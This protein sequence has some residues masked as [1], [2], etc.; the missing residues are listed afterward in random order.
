M[1]TL[2]E[3]LARH[4]AERPDAPAVV[5]Q[6]GTWT[7]ADLDGRAAAIA[8]AVIE[9]GGP[10][11]RVGLVVGA[12]ALGIAAVHGV[13][14]SG[15]S[16][17]LVHPRLTPAEVAALLA[18]AGCRL[19]VIDPAT[20][21]SA[22]AGLEVLRLDAIDSQ[23]S[24]DT[25][26][27]PGSGE[28]VVPTSGTTARP[29][30]ARLPLD[31]SAASAAAWNV[32]LP[33][34]TGWLLSLGLSHVAGLGIVSRATAAGVPIVV[35][36]ALHPQGMLDAMASAA[37]D[38]VAVSH[39]SLVAAQL[40]G[41]LDAV[42]DAAPPTTVRAVILGGGPTPAALVR[43]AIAAGW[44]IVASYGMTE[45][46]SG[47]V[48]L[49][50]ADAPAH[51][52]TVG[53]PLPGVDLRIA[54][55]GEIQ[56]RGPM[57]FA[58]YLDDPVASVAAHTAD[59]WLRTGDLGH[60]DAAGRL[61]VE[62]RADDLIVSGGENISPAEVEAALASHPAIAE[63][64]VI[65]VPDRTWGRVPVAVIAVRPDVLAAT[66][67]DLVAHARARLA[68]FK[69][70]ARFVRVPGLPRTPLGKVERRALQALA[71]PGVSAAMR[72][73]DLT[74]DNGQ[75]IAVRV[76]DAADPTSPTAVLLHATLSSGEQLGSLARR[77]AERYR[78]VLIDRRGTADSPMPEPASVP[79]ARHVG[80]VIEV[81]DVLAID[82]ALMVG[83][84]F[85]GVV[86]L[87]LAAEHGDR[88]SGVVVWE[89]PY[90]PVASAGVKDG[91]APLAGELARAFATGGAE[92]A[93]RRFLEAVSGV[94]AWDRLHPRQRAAIARQGGGALADAA[95]PGLTA[96]ELD[97]ISSPT[98]IATGGAS[99]PFY[100]PIADALA[101]RIGPAATR[102]DLPGLTHMAPITDAAAIAD[103][104][105]RLVTADLVPVPH[106][107]ESAP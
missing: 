44:P 84:S 59:R 30:L 38:G 61:T 55:D 99:D 45:T 79:V 75:A 47:I 70:P 102:V 7:W 9:R 76:I 8:A 23:G 37:D 68:R 83:H 53:R 41:V 85:G 87:R 71:G 33:P 29:K 60:L 6:G 25:T 15:V 89:P 72:R 16:A 57:C 19:L 13:A 103:L 58:G 66:D 81:L 77:L 40:A 56:V 49:Q 105:L 51:P 10:G 14:G 65:G 104:V 74:L 4:A 36:A 26:A 32:F 35:P 3:A 67:D 62:G 50:A 91:M 46:A 88:V 86:A 1:T 28:F 69:L 101:A 106:A 54:D 5:H 24:A 97:Q 20:G 39:L 90:L 93:A 52:G 11:A 64:A 63:V 42:A 21:I 82:R 96:H 95:M 107:Q 92:A 27:T 18:S 98:V 22:P 48:A 12:T 94:G 80:D 78:V 31:R 2:P 73:H 43:R 17:V 100:R 34:A